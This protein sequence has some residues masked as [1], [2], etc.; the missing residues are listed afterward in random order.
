[1][2]KN[3]R[4]FVEDVNEA[5][6]T[7][8]S[9]SYSGYAPLSLRMV[10]CAA[11]KTAVKSSQPDPKTQ[12]KAHKVDA[13]NG[14]VE[15]IKPIKGDVLVDEFEGPSNDN[16]VEEDVKKTLVFFVGGV[17]Y[18]EIASLRLMSGQ[19]KGVFALFEPS[20]TDK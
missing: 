17:T 9:Y 12:L 13:F 15:A 1:M 11:Q 20:I 2:R 4:L 10:Q 6:P 5:I 19:I 3:L 18:S 16:V 8:I 7:D 14:F